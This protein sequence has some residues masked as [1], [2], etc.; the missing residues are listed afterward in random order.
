MRTFLFDIDGVI[1]N[2]GTEIPG[3]AAALEKLRAAGKKVLFMTNNATKSPEDIVALFATFGAHA[4]PEEIMTSAVAT[5]DYLKS[6]GLAGKRVYVVGMPAL[7]AVVQERAGLET[8][9]GEEEALKTRED[10]MSDLAPGLDP[11]AETVG[12][13]VV[14]ADH[15]FNYY[16]LCRATNYL[17][18]NPN[19]LFVS[20]NP[21]P[22]ALVGPGIFAAAGGSMAAAIAYAAGKE[23]DIVCGK[24]SA[25][26]A[27][28]LLE[29]RGL[30]PEATCMVGDRLDTD[31]AFGRSGGMQS[32]IV[33]SGSMTA[34][35]L[36]TTLNEDMPVEQK[37]HFVAPS[38]AVLSD[39]L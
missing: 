29:S 31:I 34:E 4:L 8:F 11:P 9:G 16:K 13:V 6:Q 3:A 2:A 7:V 5:A 28:Y 17:R 10:F 35:E 20:T 1:H 21:D 19:C 39:L 25:S 22:V 23:P 24:P 30:D 15:K 37:P 12:A 36:R 14:G 26:L 33:E 38:I 18:A 32:L 27:R